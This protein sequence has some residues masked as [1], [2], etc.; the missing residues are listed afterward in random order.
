MTGTCRKIR[1]EVCGMNLPVTWAGGRMPGRFIPQD[2][3]PMR[4]NLQPEMQAVVG[5]RARTV[6]MGF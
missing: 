2:L 3:K 6:K 1:L 4:M 5:Y